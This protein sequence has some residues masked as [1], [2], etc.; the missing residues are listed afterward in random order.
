MSDIS[1]ISGQ[2]PGKSPGKSQQRHAPSS[3]A[4]DDKRR[5][6]IKSKEFPGH[7]DFGPE[8]VQAQ[9]V[10]RLGRPQNWGHLAIGKDGK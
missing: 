2:S 7:H 5:G 1:N 3:R 9:S 8:D 10:G 4:K 6:L